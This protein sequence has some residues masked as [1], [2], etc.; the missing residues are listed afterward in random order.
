MAEI[1]LVSVSE[2]RGASLPLLM[3][4]QN[5]RFGGLVRLLLVMNVHHDFINVRLF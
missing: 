5:T 4:E 1:A 3:A 2:G